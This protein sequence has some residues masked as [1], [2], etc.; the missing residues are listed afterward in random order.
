[1][2]PAPLPRSCLCPRFIAA[3][4]LGFF[5][6]AC[7]PRP[8]QV[9]SAE[10]VDAA[11]RAATVA[12]VQARQVAPVSSSARDGCSVAALVERVRPA[13]VGITTQRE[14]S[15]GAVSDLPPL[16]AHPFGGDGQGRSR[17]ERGMGSG[18]LIDASGLIVTNH[19]VIDG[20]DALTV[21]LADGSELSA[22]LKGDD[23]PTDL[24]LI[25]LV[26]PP[27]N[28]PAVELGD[29]DALRVGDCA[30]AIGDPF[31]L[32][33]TVTRGLISA[34][35]REITDQPYDQFLQTDAAINPGNSGGPLFDLE[36]RVVGINTAIVASAQGIGFAVPVNL[37]KAL[38]PELRSRGHVVRGYLGIVTQ[39]LTPELAAALETDAE[40]G[41][42][43]AQVAP[44]SPAAKAGLRTGDLIVE[45]QGQP[46]AGASELSREIAA[47]APGARV[48]IGY[49][50]GG[51]SRTAE[52]TLG[53]RPNEQGEAAGGSGGGAR[54]GRLGV[55]V[56]DAPA[57]A[58]EALGIEGGA[59]VVRVASG[60]RAAQAGLRPGDVVAAVGQEEVTSATAL[61]RAVQKRGERAFVLRIIRGGQ[62]RFVAVP[63]AK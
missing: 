10:L 22:T 42:L 40:E 48:E 57:A 27:P 43:V 61:V 35:A 63:A 6:L 2:T 25:E 13:V 24:A 33:L 34:K 49:R 46:V 28:L 20:A 62:P 51:K 60:S 38:L 1:M 56:R 15:G 30:V 31:G 54:A 5:A 4:A 37:L 55:E 58:V 36:G 32:E 9:A 12:P 39:T 21:R 23:A 59:Q 7:S 47:L 52:A 17:V 26:E 41:A 53:E 8:P 18:F 50:R 44:G 19:H 45:V 16:F 29:S 14:V 3:C 11:D